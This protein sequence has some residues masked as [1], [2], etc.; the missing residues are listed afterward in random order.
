[1]ILGDQT[2]IHNAQASPVLEDKRRVHLNS[3]A[4]CGMVY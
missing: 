2:E 3:Y 1:M 4:T